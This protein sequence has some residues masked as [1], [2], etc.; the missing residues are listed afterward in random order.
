VEP[1]VRRALHEEVRRVAEGVAATHRLRAEVRLEMGT[2]PLV[3]APEPT[4][5][6]R[7]AVATVLGEEALVPLGFL[8]L[9]GEDFA[10]YLERMPGCFVRVGARE[11]GG[12]VLPAHAP[13]FYAAEES[14]FVGAAVLAETAR[15]A[16]SMLR[17]G[18][19]T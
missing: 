15:V 3:N 5:W 14:L 4:Q 2:P 7:H 6:A 16:S 12:E 8:N 9:A 19:V 10:H 1:A 17:S 11:P 13:T 18:A